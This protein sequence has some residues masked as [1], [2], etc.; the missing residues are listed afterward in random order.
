MPPRHSATARTRSVR[1]SIGSRSSYSVRLEAGGFGGLADEVD[2]V[3][4]G[5]RA[6][7]L[8]DRNVIRIHG[9]AVRAELERSGREVLDLVV[10]AG[11]RSKSIA[12]ASRLWDALARASVDRSTPL[13][14]LGGGVVGDLGGFVAAT[15]MR[16][17]PLIQ[18]PTTLLAQVDSSIGGKTAVDHVLGKNLI[19]AF[20]Q[21]RA[22]FACMDALVTLPEREYKAGLAEVVKAGV[23][24]DAAL[25]ERIEQ[26]PAEVSARRPG[27]LRELVRRA[28]AVKAR[29][30]SKDPTEKGLR[31]VLNLGHT[32]AHA[33]EQID[34]YRGLLH[35][36]AVAI[37]L[38]AAARVSRR[39]GWT[40]ADVAGRI[41]AVLE[42][43]GLPTRRPGLSAE[44]VRAA[45]DRD[46]KA[47]GGAVRFVA[48]VSIGG[49]TL[50]WIPVASLA[51]QLVAA[52]A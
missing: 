41:C 15:Y 20:Y 10:A 43:L 18:V 27:L 11:E 17:I 32:L 42:V 28:I 34:G 13:V 6:V 52:A 8:T 30:V 51:K 1:V 29:V 14:A 4:P 48:P 38:A 36:E 46:K 45:L 19:G 37:G 23:L 50:H 24:G 5:R 22:V 49:T 21:P 2:A 7:L 40:T 12:S 3:A 16:G 25:F 35:G 33:I 26:H 39:H 44:H 47:A 31:A 9:A